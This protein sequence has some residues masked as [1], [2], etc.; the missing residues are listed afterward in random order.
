MKRM[1]WLAGWTAVACTASAA[2]ALTLF[3]VGGEGLPE[4]ELEVPFEFVQLSWEEPDEN[5]FG[6]EISL[7]RRPEW[8]TPEVSD[9]GVNLSP[10][11]LQGNLVFLAGGDWAIPERVPGWMDVRFSVRMADEDSDSYYTDHNSMIYM[12]DLQRQIHLRRV[13]FFTR[14]DD[15]N[16]VTCGFGM[17]ETLTVCRSGGIDPVPRFL[18]AVSDGDPAKAGTRPYT[19]QYNNKTHPSRRHDFDVIHEGTGGKL[20][21]LDFP[22]VPTQRL[23]FRIFAQEGVDW[24]IA[25]FEIYGSGFVPFS[26]YTSNVIDL[27]EVLSIGDLTWS[28]RQGEELGTRVDITMRSGDDA[29]PEVYW[30][31]TFRGD[32]QV[33]FSE[34]GTPLTKAQYRRLEIPEQGDIRHDKDNWLTWNTPYDFTAGSGTAHAGRPRRFVQFDVAFHSTPESGSE[35][36]YLQF[37]ASPPLVTGAAAEINP[38]TAAAGELTTFTCRLRPHLEPGDNG[39]DLIAIDTPAQVSGVDEVARIGGAEIDIEITRMDG[40][41]FAVKVPR[42]DPGST[43]E[44][45]ELTFEAR[46]FEYGTPFIPRLSDSELPFEVPQPVVEGDADEGHDGN[47]LRVA[48]TAIPEDPI[49]NLRLSSPVV[50]P[51]GDGA[52]DRVEIEYQ[53]LNL[54]GEVPAAIG[55]YEL[56]GRKV[57]KIGVGAG[58]VSGLFRV[59]WDGSGKRGLLPPGLYLL[60]VEVDADTGRNQSGRLV[61]VAY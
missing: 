61:S 24:E 38:N 32:E 16:L 51:N 41:G 11:M 31:Y 18:I 49:R 60:Q 57:G 44:L 28:G 47:G 8:I 9:P 35:V 50:T 43:G 55:I 14:P 3:R 48:L 45:I 19:L 59:E 30:R 54:T 12:F 39:F 20:I 34:S 37:A 58:P 27:G 53:L 40:E 25:E 21:D 42:V 26:R 36:D 7:D 46:V 4:P 1:Q 22:S 33:P 52:N 6:D 2:G 13:R 10:T 23:L 29:Q 15:G 17:A 56:S 5:R